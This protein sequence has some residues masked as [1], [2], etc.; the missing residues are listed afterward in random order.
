ML[1]GTQ[2]DFGYDS[3]A[4]LTFDDE[5]AFQAFFGRTSVGDA[6]AKRAADEEQFLDRRRMR[7]VVL[8]DCTVEGQ[9]ASIVLPDCT[10]YHTP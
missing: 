1:L 6:G 2:S 4:E 7:I 9:K 5:T 3:I 8:G 10:D